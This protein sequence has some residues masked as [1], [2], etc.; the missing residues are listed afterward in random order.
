MVPDT[1]KALHADTLKPVNLPEVVM[2]REIAA[3]PVAIKLNR[4]WLEVERLEESWRLDDEWWRPQPLVR[5][6]YAVILSGGRRI[7]VFKDLADGL[8]YHQSY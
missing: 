8:W 4:C 5:R 6:Y 3:Q 1:G 2:V 7:T